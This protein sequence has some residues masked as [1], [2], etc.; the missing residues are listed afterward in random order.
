[1]TAS[2]R[3]FADNTADPKVSGLLHLPD[4]P[5]GNALVLTHGAG[6]NA[7]APL[8][9]ALADAFCAAGFTVLRCDLPYRQARSFGPPGPGDAAR[10]RAGLKNAIAAISRVMSEDGGAPRLADFARPGNSEVDPPLSR[11]LRQGGD[12]EKNEAVPLNT[13]LVGPALSDP[14]QSE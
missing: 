8:L 13:P 2:I 5:N 7:Q 3:A 6:S 14:E 11:S 4:T 9:R 12:S 1:M 10:D